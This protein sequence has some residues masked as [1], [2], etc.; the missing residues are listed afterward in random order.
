MNSVWEGFITFNIPLTIGLC[1]LIFMY[2]NFKKYRQGEK[3]NLFFYAG[4][5]I[6]ISIY[7]FS[8][9]YI[10]NVEIDYMVSWFISATLIISVIQALFFAFTG[11]FLMSKKTKGEK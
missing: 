3:I 11:S 10:F 1:Y 4:W 9:L 5:S 7:I 2:E 8:S 6:F